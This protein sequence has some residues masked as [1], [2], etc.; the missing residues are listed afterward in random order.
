MPMFLW[1][2]TESA[3]FIRP[4]SQCRRIDRFAPNRST[5]ADAWLGQSWVILDRIGLSRHVRFPPV[6]EHGANIAGCLKR[7]RRL[8]HRALL[9]LFYHLVGAGKKGGRNV[10]AQGTR[11]RRIDHQIE[12]RR[13]LNGQIA[14]LSTF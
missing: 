6:S 2:P 1:L 5:K 7:A 8:M 12:L 4:I 3:A 11:C 9:G 14:W 13:L 10:D